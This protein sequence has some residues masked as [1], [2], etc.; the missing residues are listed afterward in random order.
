MSHDFR[1]GLITGIAVIVLAIWALG[2]FGKLFAVETMTAIT[3]TGWSYH[4]D[5]KKDRCEFNPGIGLEHGRDLRWHFG[6]YSNSDCRFS[7]YGGP[8]YSRAIAGNWR[9]GVALLG[10]TG[11]HKE[12]KINGKVEHENKVILA[13]ILVLAYEGKKRGVNIGYVP[14]YGD[15]NGV[16]FVQLKVLRW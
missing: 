4:F 14:P 7:G 5:R 16:I 12:K 10:V 15:D 1:N 6:I 11:Y 9:A 13:P 8:S 3:A 2:L